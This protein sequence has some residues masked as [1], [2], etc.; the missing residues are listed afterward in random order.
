VTESKQHTFTAFSLQ[1][2]KKKKNGPTKKFLYIKKLKQKKQKKKKH[3]VLSKKKKKKKKTGQANT[4]FQVNTS[5][6]NFLTSE[7]EYRRSQ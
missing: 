1:K 5:Y 2:K 4:L 3:I 6:L 7:I